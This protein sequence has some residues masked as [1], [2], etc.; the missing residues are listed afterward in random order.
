MTESASPGAPGA[1]PAAATISVAR[2]PIFNARCE[3][4]AFEL[5]YRGS[6]Q[7]VQIDRID[8]TLAT[9]RVVLGAISDIGL[10]R[11][12]PDVRVHVNLPDA[13]LREPLLLPLSPSRVVIE[14]LENVTVDRALLEG[15]AA[16]RAQGFRIA[17]DDYTSHLCDPRLLGVADC[18][19][20][21]LAN[22][23]AETLAATVESLHRRGL[24]LIAEKVETREQFEHCR[25][26]GFAGFQGYFLQRPE[27]FSGQRAPTMRVTT[28]QVLAALNRPDVTP[29]ELE[30]LV[31][32]DLGLVNRLL[33]CLNSGYYHLP[34]KV[35]SI[36]HGIVMLGLENLKRLCSVVALAGF[37]DRPNY[38]LVN[39]M[40]RARMCELMAEQRQ[41]SAAGSFFF[42]GLLSHIDALLG[43]PTDE[44]VRSLPLTRDIENALTL[45][46]GPIGEALR[47]VQAW[48]RGEWDLAL[49]GAD[50]R[51]VRAAYLEA[52]RWAEEARRMLG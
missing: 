4:M 34:R 27:T 41:P 17:L 19:K 49:S 11:L 36:R 14:V 25:A 10:E 22:E 21:D 33:R 1:A 47:E 9:A 5:L 6:P 30:Q 50:A 26:L 45:H 2:Q 42:A 35:T 16:L 37:E 28:L 40:V 18:V 13:L 46:A 20:I 23:P 7:A 51:D 15:I 8:G 29:E 48:E 3:V 44:A 32:R 52:L 39:A 31:S 38:L 12:A 24:D 43:L